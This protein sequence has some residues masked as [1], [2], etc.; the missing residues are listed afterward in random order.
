MDTEETVETAEVETDDQR[1]E[2]LL[3]AACEAEAWFAADLDE[4]GRIPWPGNREGAWLKPR[5]MDGP[6]RTEY[7]GMGRKY[8]FDA[9][10]ASVSKEIAG[11]VNQR[12]R[13]EF[14]VLHCVDE[15]C[16]LK[17]GK[18]LTPGASEQ[19]NWSETGFWAD[20][21]LAKRG[22]TEIETKRRTAIK[23]WLLGKDGP[24][25][26]AAHWDWLVFQCLKANGLL[27]S[28]GN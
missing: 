1:Q 8:L 19:W 25:L 12:E 28:Q 21:A 18:V 13:E 17:R 23:K 15:F 10:K 3:L 14:L 20:E 9:E 16:I 5:R 26:S 22:E 11:T 4:L 24:G 6:T 7:E 2:R 27:P